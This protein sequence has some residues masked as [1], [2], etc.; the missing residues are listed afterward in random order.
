MNAP[1][2]ISRRAMLATAAGFGLSLQLLAAPAIAADGTANRK[3]L[4]VVIC[5][6]G[7]DGLSVSPPVRDPDYAGLRG[8]R[9]PKGSPPLITTD[10]PMARLLE[11]TAT[12]YAITQCYRFVPL[13]PPRLTRHGTNVV[14]AKTSH[15]TPPLVASADWR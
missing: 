6:G 2:N 12:N 4:I 15:E 1:L 7:M 14:E 3:K 8:L 9:L 11:S 13:D 10:V 5:R